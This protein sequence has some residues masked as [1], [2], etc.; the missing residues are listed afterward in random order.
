MA[1]KGVRG[2]AWGKQRINKAFLKTLRE[3]FSLGEAFTNRDAYTLYSDFHAKKRGYWDRQWLEMNV[4][5]N[6]CTMVVRGILTRR[7]LGVYSFP[8]D[9]EGVSND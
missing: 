2:G 8:L 7:G 5:N 1:T 6:L 3:A 4:R 9:K